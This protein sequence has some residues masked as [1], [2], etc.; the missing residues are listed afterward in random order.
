MTSSRS[1]SGASGRQ[2]FSEKK[3]YK[4]YF[5]PF[6]LH[7][8]FLWCSGPTWSSPSLWAASSTGIP[9]KEALCPNSEG[10]QAEDRQWRRSS[11][12]SS[13]SSSSPSAPEPGSRS[14]A[15]QK[16]F[17]PPGPDSCTFSPDAAQKWWL[18]MVGWTWKCPRTRKVAKSK[19]LFHCS[20]NTLYYSRIPQVFLLKS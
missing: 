17:S 20:P 18:G 9:S 4:K 3:R 15:P 10:D 16:R 7:L 1:P 5:G 13:S 2:F 6:I 12:S 11:S 19:S 14:T 8:T